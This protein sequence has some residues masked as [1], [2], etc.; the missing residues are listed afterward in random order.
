MA[1]LSENCAMDVLKL[2]VPSGAPWEFL[3]TA[4]GIFAEA[5]RGISYKPPWKSCCMFGV[6]PGFSCQLCLFLVSSFPRLTASSLTC[7]STGTFALT[8][9]VAVCCLVG[10]HR[11][12]VGAL[13]DMLLTLHRFLTHSHS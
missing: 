13:L 12:I 6:R 4:H 11:H 10:S 5:P 1:T 7:G 9:C 2:T 3:N 8:F